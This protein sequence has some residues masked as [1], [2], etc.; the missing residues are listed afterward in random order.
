M[1]L[2]KIIVFS[3]LKKDQKKRKKGSV[4]PVGAGRLLEEAIDD[5][6]KRLG[7]RRVRE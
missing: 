2:P 6:W 3:Q 4:I 5:I 7:R 1:I